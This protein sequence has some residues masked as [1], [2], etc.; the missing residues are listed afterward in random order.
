MKLDFI[1]STQK[2]YVSIRPLYEF[3]RNKGW[4]SSIYRIRKLAVRNYFT[5]KKLSNTVVIAFDKPLKRIQK[6]GWKGRYIY[7]EHGLGP[8]KYYTY[9]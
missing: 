1:W 9:K 5:I 4:D 7:I 8:I 3:L 2:G 6:S